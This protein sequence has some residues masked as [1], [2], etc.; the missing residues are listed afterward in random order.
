MLGPH[1]VGDMLVLGHKAISFGHELKAGTP[2]GQ[3]MISQGVCA[4]E[5]SAR[6]RDC[7]HCAMTSAHA[8]DWLHMSYHGRV[9]M[10]AEGRPYRQSD[11][12]VCGAMLEH[13]ALRCPASKHAV[14][15]ATCHASRAAFRCAP[16]HTA[17]GRAVL[18]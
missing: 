16:Y 8:I 1:H 11:V 5:M 6:L 2:M 4:P 18:C 13:A 15:A 7:L 10:H 3:Y 17:P 12:R 9:W 14:C